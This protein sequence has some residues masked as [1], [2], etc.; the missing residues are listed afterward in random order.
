MRVATE[1][2]LQVNELTRVT[3]MWVLRYRIILQGNE[4][5]RVTVVWAR[6]YRTILQGNELT[7]RDS[8]VGG[9]LPNYAAG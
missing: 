9:L 7:P 3:L 4:L 1:L 2:N 5:T 6:R 8:G